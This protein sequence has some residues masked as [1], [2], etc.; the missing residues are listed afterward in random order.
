MKVV[1]FSMGILNNIHFVKEN[2][3]FAFRGLSPIHLSIF[4][5]YLVYL[6]WLVLLLNKHTLTPTISSKS[7]SNGNLI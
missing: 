3:L 1:L 2:V 5:L 7:N 4:P 6:L